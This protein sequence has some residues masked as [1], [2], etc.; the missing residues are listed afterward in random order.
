[1]IDL[2]KM[3]EFLNSDCNLPVSEEMIGAYAEGKL[4]GADFM[5]V[6]Y[7]IDNH[8]ELKDFISE[9]TSNE[10]S[11]PFGSSCNVIES[12]LPELPILPDTWGNS[13]T[14]DSNPFEQS[15]SAYDFG[16]CA[17]A[18]PMQDDLD[19]PNDGIST[20]SSD[21]FFASGDSFDNNEDSLFTD[22]SSDIDDLL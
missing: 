20:N 2:G 4:N 8:P 1:M 22:D 5:M 9:D 15:I 10:L 7:A 21:D 3:E 16:L 13:N 19:N 6:H 11:I 14:L 12:E 17:C 18:A